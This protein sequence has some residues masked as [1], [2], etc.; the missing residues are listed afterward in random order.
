MCSWLRIEPFSSYSFFPLWLGYILFMDALVVARCGTSLLKR[1]RMRYL[2]LFLFSSLFW[3]LFE[4]F[5]V[6]V[7]NWHYIV[8]RPYSPF[9]YFLL[10]SLNFSTVLPAVMETAEFLST[11]DL[12]H[13]RLSADTPGPRL[14]LYL[15]III[16]LLGVV[17]LLLP[18]FFPHYAFVL[19][20]LCLAL[21]LEPIN[22][23]VGRKSALAHIAVGDWRFCV[24]PLAGLWCGLLWEMWNF[25]ALPKW[26]YTIPFIGFWKIFEMPLLGY[27]GYLPFAVELF[28]LYQFI[29]FLLRQPDDYLA[30]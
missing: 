26:Y 18:I 23:F 29:L 21:L 10:A 24:L 13:P 2:Q 30:I 22:N 16:A 20:W 1:M 14:P 3:W 6:P 11:F 12:L 4:A 19:V 27:S 28:A 17:S 15:L 5:N 9:A 25:Y 8:D 7:Q